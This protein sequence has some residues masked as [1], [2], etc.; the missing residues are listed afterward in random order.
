MF[1]IQL[2]L[3]L[4]LKGVQNFPIQNSRGHF[5]LAATKEKKRLRKIKWHIKL[6]QSS[7]CCSA[8]TAEK[9]CLLEAQ[10]NWQITTL[11]SLN[12]V[13]SKPTTSPV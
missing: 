2:S 13:Q 7:R 6:K 3:N 12:P 9:E 11:N 1:L 8:K 4:L 5:N 10:K